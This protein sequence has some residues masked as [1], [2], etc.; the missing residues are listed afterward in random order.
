MS[1]V[2]QEWG[3][4]AI[5]RSPSSP[6]VLLPGL[7]PAAPPS[8]HLASSLPRTPHL[9]CCWAT[10][11]SISNAPG[12]RARAPPLPPSLTQCQSSALHPTGV[13]ERR[14]PDR[15]ARLDKT[16]GA[17]VG[18]RQGCLQ[19]PA[20]KEREGSPRSSSAPTSIAAL[21][22]PEG[23]AQKEIQYLS[24]RD[25]EQLDPTTKLHRG[26]ATY[27][28]DDRALKE[29]EPLPEESSTQV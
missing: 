3:E 17:L 13:E 20:R 12:W 4:S 18:Q 19:H 8:A 16:P 1:V 22:A 2:T 26:R 21:A 23:D 29:E 5:Y 9:D 15:K 14:H 6:A 25:G 28:M 10:A 24:T 27:L 11:P 7:Y